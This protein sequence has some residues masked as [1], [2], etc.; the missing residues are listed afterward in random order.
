[1][2]PVPVAVVRPDS[3]SAVARPVGHTPMRAPDTAG[4]R[5]GGGRRRRGVSD[6]VGGWWGGNSN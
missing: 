4:K 3:V 6:F 2:V 5:G 1:V